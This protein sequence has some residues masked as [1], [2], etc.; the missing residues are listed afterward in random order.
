AAQVCVNVRQYRALAA[1]RPKGLHAGLQVF[2]RA[3]E[4]GGDPSVELTR[5]ALDRPRAAPRAEEH[6]RPSFGA[7]PGEEAPAVHARAG[8]AVAA[9]E[10]AHYFEAFPERRDPRVVIRAGNLEAGPGRS[11]ADAEPQPSCEQN[12]QRL[13]AVRKLAGPSQRHLQHASTQL[14]MARA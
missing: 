5:G 6:R 14:D 11:R 2:P 3:V 13:N 1:M 12:V 7:G 10:R 9:P 8:P 4:A